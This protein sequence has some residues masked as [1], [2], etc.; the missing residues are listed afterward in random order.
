MPVSP[1]LRAKVLEDFHSK[2]AKSATELAKKH[3]LSRSSVYRILTKDAHER[4]L[5]SAK[6]TPASGPASGPT[7]RTVV[8]KH[9]IDHQSS[10]RLSERAAESEDESGDESGSEDGDSDVSDAFFYRS[11]KFADDLGLP[12]TT[13]GVK[14]F[15][16]D[17][18]PDAAP[19]DEDEVDA[20]FDRI[21]GGTGTS[22]PSSSQPPSKLLD[23]VLAMPAPAPQRRSRMPRVEDPDSEDGEDDWVVPTQPRTLAKGVYP[24]ESRADTTQRIIFNVEHFHSLLKPLVG[25]SKDVFLQSLASRSDGD[26]RNLLLTLERTRSV[27]NLA[28]GFK[29][30]FYVVGQA[31]E[32]LTQMVGMR[33]QGF[34]DH[35]R[36]QDEEIAMIMKELAMDQ[37]QTLKEMDKPELRLGA[38]FCLTL[39][40]TDG[41]NRMK[42]Q[43]AHALQG[44]RVSSAT[45]EAHADL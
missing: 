19:V 30:T 40:Q 16:D 42:E 38:L 13:V 33:T 32:V 15:V 25:E 23:E 29:Q 11:D 27:G 12:S 2:K 9:T 28:S 37:W 18:G 20:V 1:D 21:A 14:N 36:T 17:E 44:S 10:S 24:S 43:V 8:L 39:V 26:L 6:G 45:V 41:Q 35:L 4:E 5:Q 3:G 22:Q 34:A 7:P 31:T